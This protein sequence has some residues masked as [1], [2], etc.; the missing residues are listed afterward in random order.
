MCYPQAE[1]N[2]GV[3]ARRR[4]E[5]RRERIETGKQRIDDAFSVFSP[6]YFQGVSKDYQGYYN[7]QVDDQFDDARQGLKYN[8]ARAGIQDSTAANKTFGKLTD[9]Y[10]DRRREVA[11]KALEASNNIR[12]QVEQNKN[13]LYSQNTASANPSLAAISAVGTAGSLQSPPAFSPLGD[14]FSGLV[15]GAA[16]Y[17]AGSNRGLPPQYRPY[18]AGSGLPSGGG[19]SYVVS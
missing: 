3:A 11:D 19:S 13:Q 9:A 8:L 6:E 12:S 5:A 14:L 4:E 16:T 10:S 17:Y 1:D 15:N 18:F 7:T 2:S